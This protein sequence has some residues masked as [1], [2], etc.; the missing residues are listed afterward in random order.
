MPRYNDIAKDRVKRCDTY[1]C[2]GTKLEGTRFELKL[3]NVPKTN[4]FESVKIAFASLSLLAFS[5][6]LQNFM[7]VFQ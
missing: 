7:T 1:K 3:L 5:K 4:L 6:F 2:Q